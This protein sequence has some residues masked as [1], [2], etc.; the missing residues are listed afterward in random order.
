MGR[1]FTLFWGDDEV[2]PATY[3]IFLLLQETSGVRPRLRAQ[4]RQQPTFPAD[5]FCLIHQEFNK[6]FHQELERQKR[7]RSPNFESLRRDLVTGN[8][9]PDLVA[10]PGGIAPPERPLPP[11][12]APRLQ[13]SDKTQPAA[14]T[15]PKLQA[16][17]RRNQVQDHNP[18]PAP[19]M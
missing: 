11:P 14:G 3:K 12:A 2:H 1:V 9:C 10:L 5:L 4:A 15:T 13:A 19:Q 16:Q 6:S 8:F 17:I 7:V 18:Y